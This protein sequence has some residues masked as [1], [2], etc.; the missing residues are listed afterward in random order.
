[1]RDCLRTGSLPVGHL[2]YD[3]DLDHG[4]QD[5]DSRALDKTKGAL[6]IKPSFTDPQ[7]LTRF[8]TVSPDTRSVLAVERE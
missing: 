8:A 5:P 2:N 3:R 6:E 4:L 7:T 1:M